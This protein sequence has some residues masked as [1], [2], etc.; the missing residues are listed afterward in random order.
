MRLL[1][2][3]ENKRNEILYVCLDLTTG[4]SNEKGALGRD[5]LRVRSCS[6]T[7]GKHVSVS[8]RTPLPYRREPIDG[9]HIFSDVYSG[10]E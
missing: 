10:E 1:N 5:S 7:K 9:P 2:R 8:A 4:D 6:K 3:D